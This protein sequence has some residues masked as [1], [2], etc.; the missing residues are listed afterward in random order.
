MI[1]H[2]FLLDVEL[3]YYFLLFCLELE[4]EIEELKSKA[5]SGGA[6]DIIQVRIH[7]GFLMHCVIIAEIDLQK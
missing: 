3:L 5:A 1:K 6:D 7:N 4:K 2:Q